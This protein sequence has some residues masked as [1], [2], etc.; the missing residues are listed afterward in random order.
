MVLEASV[1]SHLQCSLLPAVLL[2]YFSL[3]TSFGCRQG[4]VSESVAR[5][6][7]P[8]FFVEGKCLLIW[9]SRFVTLENIHPSGTVV[10]TRTLLDKLLM[11][12]VIKGSWPL[13]K[14]ILG[15]SGY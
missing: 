1:S 12:G 4:A 9:L 8:V 5:V 3:N 15:L 14:K 7:H 11:P 6:R 10:R 13:T 2:L